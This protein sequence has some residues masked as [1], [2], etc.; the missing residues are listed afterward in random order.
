MSKSFTNLTQDKNF[1]KEYL[2]LINNSN[3]FL[4][5]INQE[6][7][8]MGDFFVKFSLYQEQS[9]SIA[10]GDTFSINDNQNA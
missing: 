2:E 1:E 7:I 10:S 5:G 8:K 9:T 6:W 4:F 3:N